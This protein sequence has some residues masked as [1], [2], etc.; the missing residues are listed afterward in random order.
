VGDGL[1]D[2]LKL[3][4]GS[5]EGTRATR[6]RGEKEHAPRVGDGEKKESVD[7]RGGAEK[8]GGVEGSRTCNLFTIAIKCCIG[9]FST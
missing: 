4:R 1:E 3:V 6:E 5:E 9:L 7:E 2:I 8:R